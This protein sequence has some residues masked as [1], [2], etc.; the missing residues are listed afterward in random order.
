MIDEIPQAAVEALEFYVYRLVDPRNGKTFYVG[1][2]SGQRALQ[3]LRAALRDAVPSDP[4]DDCIQK[5]LASGNEVTVIIHRHG[6][7]EPT[8]LAV[9]A[10][11]I[12]AYPGLTNLVDGHR[13]EFGAAPL[14][15][16]IE[17]YAARPAEIRVPAILIRIEREWHPSL[18][19]EQLY[20]RTRRY[21]ACTPERRTP[22]PTHAMSVARGL[23]REVYRITGWEKYRD[24]P[25][26]RDPSRLS[27][28]RDKWKPGQLRRGFV[29]EVDAGLSHLRGCSV[30]YLMKPGAQNPITYVNC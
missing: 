29:G 3:H 16:I 27:T 4:L 7:D 1:K 17:R 6:M 21:W 26:D 30:R 9:E 23:I 20:E 24:W 14:P 11:L 15:E 19:A 22:P 2:G 28:G 12:D 18:K 5:I 8:A 10:A 25:A 13:V